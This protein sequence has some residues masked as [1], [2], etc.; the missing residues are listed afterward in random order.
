MI[1]NLEK[2]WWRR[3]LSE[4]RKLPLFPVAI[5]AA[6][7]FAGLFGPFITPHDPLESNLMDAYTP[8]FFQKEGTTKYLLG[9]DHMGRDI[10]SR[11]IGGARISIM[12]GF[13]VVFIAGSIGTIFA[14]VGGY[15]RGW[16]DSF[17]MRLT[18][19]FLSLPFLMVALV[20]AAVLGASI[21]NII[22]VL[23][24]MGWAG[25]ARVLRAEVLRLREADFVRLAI[26]AGCSRAKILL[27]HIFPNIMNTLIVLASL[28]LGVTIIAEASL[29]FLGMGVPPPNPAWGL[30][31]AQGK[32]YI[33]FSWW[34]CFWPGLAIMLTVLSCNLLGDWLRV[35]LDPKFRQL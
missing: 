32:D 33:T 6:V 14:M 20:M 7:I 22:I 28:Q 35:R 13:T 10:L 31:L 8:P 34:I 15:F 29:S 26:T 17:L 5:L 11:L 19:T 3:C 18:D 23:V 1:R 24:V 2:P 16:W 12:V 27:K 25:Y 4:F 30:M 21:R 9:T